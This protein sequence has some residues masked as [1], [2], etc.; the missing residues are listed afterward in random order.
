MPPNPMLLGHDWPLDPS[1]LSLP[2]LSNLSA[3]KKNKNKLKNKL[4]LERIFVNKGLLF[5]VCLICGK[6]CV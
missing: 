3:N 6:T 2:C 5:V 4:L 1:L